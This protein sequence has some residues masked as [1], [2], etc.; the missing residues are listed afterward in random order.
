MYEYIIS[1]KLP[2]TAVYRLHKEIVRHFSAGGDL[3]YPERPIWRSKDVGGQTIIICRST[4][5]PRTP[6]QT[7]KIS[8]QKQ[9]GEHVQFLAHLSLSHRLKDENNR[10]ICEYPIERKYLTE[11]LKDML[12]KKG[13]ELQNCAFFNARQIIVKE[14]K[15]PLSSADVAFNVIIIDPEM[16]EEAYYKGLGARRAFGCGMLIED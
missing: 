8:F 4:T 13:M 11:W 7:T 5:P 6:T 12:A 16:A 2:S 10:T 14:K 3:P 9:A 15:F 1:S